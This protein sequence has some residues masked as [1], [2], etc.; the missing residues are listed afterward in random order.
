[1]SACAVVRGG[2]GGWPPALAERMLRL[3]VSASD[4]RWRTSSIRSR[5]LPCGFWGTWKCDASFDSAA[6]KKAET[7]FLSE[8]SGRRRLAPSFLGWLNSCFSSG[9]NESR[10]APRWKNPRMTHLFLL[11][12]CEYCEVRIEEFFEFFKAA[13]T[14]TKIAC[15]AHKSQELVV[16]K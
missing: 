6:S 13:S 2:S 9:R 14:F 8:A 5:R 16:F 3:L 4:R 7:R 12:F 11:L 15:A 10:C 1:M